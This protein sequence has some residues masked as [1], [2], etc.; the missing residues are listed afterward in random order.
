MAGSEADWWKDMLE[1]GNEDIE[2]RG[3]GRAVEAAASIAAAAAT[4]AH[5]AT[6]AHTHTPTEVQ[7]PN[8]EAYTHTLPREHLHHQHPSLNLTHS[9]A[10]CVWRPAGSC[11][12]TTCAT[13]SPTSLLASST[14]L[15]ALCFPRS[16]TARRKRGTL[17][18]LAA[19][20]RIQTR[21]SICNPHQGF[22]CVPQPLL[23]CA[24]GPIRRGCRSGSFLTMF[25]STESSWSLSLSPIHPLAAFTP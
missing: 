19:S 20:S 5:T 16:S 22:C 10:V 2:L 15:S 7:N 13:L 9:D 14:R 3:S 17:S 25:A 8:V 4:P 24:F 18:G 21:K 23:T 1:A 11:S 12:L 6:H